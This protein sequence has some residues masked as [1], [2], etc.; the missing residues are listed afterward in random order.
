MNFHY[1]RLWAGTEQ[2]LQ[3]H[4]QSMSR[5][6]SAEIKMPSVAVESDEGSRLLSKVGSVGVID[7]R[8][9]LVNSSGDFFTMFFGGTGYGEI[10][11]AAVEAAIDP[12]VK[13]VLLNIHSG[14]GQVSGLKSV[15]D[16]LTRLDEKVKP[17][18]TYAEDMMASAAYRLGASSRAIYAGDEASIGSIGVLA[19]HQEYSKMMEKDGVT[20]KIIRSGPFKALGHPAEPLSELAEETI[21]KEVNWFAEKFTR[22]MAARR[23]TPYEAFERVA[24]QGRVLFGEQSLQANLVDGIATFEEVLESIERAVSKK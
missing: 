12:E 19:V 2:S 5:L 10:R 8:G 13:S 18:F 23:N 7:I 1:D 20:A 11:Q 16:L 6:L 9:S 24:G 22:E 3:H 15:A 4:L 21:Q 14:G 17:V